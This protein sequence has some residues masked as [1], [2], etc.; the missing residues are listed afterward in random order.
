MATAN[1]IEL[2]TCLKECLDYCRAKTGEEFVD[3]YLPRLEHAAQKWERSVEMSDKYYLQWQKE[4]IEDKLA[5]KH[6]GAE[7]RATQKMLARLGAEGY[8]KEIFYHWD[9][10]ILTEQVEQMIAYLSERKDVIDEAPAAIQGLQRRLD[11][12]TGETSEMDDALH[13][14]NR[15]VMFRA[16][17]MGT[18]SNVLSN[19]RE[20]MRRQL[21][22]KNPEYKSIRWPLT[23]NPDEP[24][25]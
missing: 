14:Y 7:L 25:L 2:E 16:E 3:F 6:L 22:K 1:V 9:E 10:E 23:L 18:L 8:D 21:G 12:A 24:V 13:E 4:F 19:F 17:A 5:W 20:S 15:H 11:A